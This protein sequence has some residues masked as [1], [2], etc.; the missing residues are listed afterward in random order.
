M[1]GLGGGEGVMVTTTYLFYSL[2]VQM[3]HLVTNSSSFGTRGLK[4]AIQNQS[5]ISH[6]FSLSLSPS[7]LSLCRVS[8]SSAFSFF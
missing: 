1:V 8:I 7:S 3:S 4:I 6:V 2:S 5:S